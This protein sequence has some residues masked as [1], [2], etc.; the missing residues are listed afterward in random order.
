MRRVDD[1]RQ[2]RAFLDDRHDAQI[3]RVARVFLKRP[4]AAF[5]QDHVLVAP[6]HDVLRRHDPLLDRIR[7]PALQ[8]H[9]LVNLAQRFQQIEVL[10]VARSDLNQIDMLDKFVDLIRAHQFADD[11]QTGLFPRLDHRENPF[12]AH[13]LKSVR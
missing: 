2:M 5:A 4:N 8:Q 12:G 7:Q 9:R 11:R 3:Q 1:D 13:P 6:G 10:H